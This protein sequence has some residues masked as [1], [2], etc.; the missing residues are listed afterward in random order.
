MCGR[1]QYHS[2]GFRGTERLLYYLLIIIVIYYYNR[3]RFSW[4]LIIPAPPVLLYT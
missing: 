3:S 2:P 4:T 1:Y